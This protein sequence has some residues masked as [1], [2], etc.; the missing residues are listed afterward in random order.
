MFIKFNGSLYNADV[1]SCFKVVR[2][3]LLCYIPASN[4][5][6]C[7]M[8]Y[9]SPEFASFAFGRIIHGMLGKW[10]CVDVTEEAIEHLYLEKREAF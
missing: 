3:E 5:P 8:H 6:L 2:N 10:G 7:S 1:F 4:K 9:A